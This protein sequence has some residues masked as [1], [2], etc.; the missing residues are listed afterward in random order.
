M[1]E[2]LTAAFA[3]VAVLVVGTF[4]LA[5]A[6]SVDSHVTAR[7]TREVA[8][9]ARWLAVVVE[10]R[11]AAH[12]PVDAAFLR[13]LVS[14][15]ERLEYVDAAGVP[16]RAAG[17]GFGAPG[18]D[19]VV[20]SRPV[21]GG[22][23][24]VRHSGDAVQ[25]AVASTVYP[26]VLL[27]IVLVLV[28]AALGYVAAWLLA[29]PFRELAEHAR[30][31]G[32]GRFDIAARHSGVP[33]AE[34]IAQALAASGRQLR[35]LLHRERRFAAEA[36]HEL[37]TPITAL[38]LELE[39]LAG[40]PALPAAG[41]AQVRRALAEVDRLAGSVDLLL[42][43]TRQGRIATGD[44]TDVA[45]LV[46]EAARRGERRLGQGR[47]VLTDA[48]TPAVVRLPPGPIEQVLDALVE[49]AL[50]EGEGTVTLQV[51]DAGDHVHVRVSDEATGAGPRPGAQA[52][53]E[54]AQA[55]GARIAF[56]PGPG[57]CLGV[58]LPRT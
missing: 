46:A 40:D 55:L 48:P 29:R 56:E 31:L 23:V 25:A 20:R 3:L 12:R 10:E 34:S 8:A 50:R 26:L 52:A 13:R 27:G 28:A 9:S 53:A 58:R 21:D 41:T 35:E 42:E 45:A 57:T 54:A 30:A 7:Q 18:D 6:Y 43:R 15:D 14:P 44:G 49:D 5:R 32:R 4:A 11:L 19:D 2:R 47:L 36:S 51:R 17:P 39:D 37:R 33:E 38:R 22:T 1:R 24:R 16:V